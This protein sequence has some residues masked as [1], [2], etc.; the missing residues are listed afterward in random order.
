MKTLILNG[1]PR[2]DGDTVA[3]IEELKKYLKGEIL[4][5]NPFYNKIAPCDDCRACWKKP[6]CIIRDD[7]DKVYTDD[8]DILVVASPLHMS[9][10]PGPLV[11]LASRLQVYYASREKLHAPIE[12]RKKEAVMILVGGGDGSPSVAIRQTKTIF[13]LLWAKLADENVVMS[14]DTDHV[15]AEEDQ[16]AIEQ[17]RDVALRLNGAYGMA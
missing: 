1:S 13:S 2:K 12:R 15:P 6:K 7:M 17:V 3:L 10:L 4:E 14:M 16:T 8:Y 11:N 9:S 5:L